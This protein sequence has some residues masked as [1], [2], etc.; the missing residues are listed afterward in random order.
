MP[1]AIAAAAALANRRFPGKVLIDGILYLPLVL[2]PVVLG[3]LLLVILGTRAPLGGWFVAHLGI[4]FV[5]SWTGAALAS[6][7][8]TF[9]FQVRAIRFSIEAIDPGLRSVAETLGAGRLDR[10]LHVT[11]PLA[12]P[13]IVVG[14]LTAFAA[15]LG[16]FGAIITFVSNIP[17]ETRT[18]PLAIYAALQAPGGDMEAARLSALSIALALIGVTLAELASRR[19][20]LLISR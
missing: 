20:R 2:P 5:F 6:A 1:L 15:S 4:R 9:P 10:L 11:L 14:A 18:L 19:A 3:Y 16:E 7:L 13:G 12:L 8:L 17:G